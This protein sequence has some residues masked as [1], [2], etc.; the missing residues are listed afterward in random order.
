[1]TELEKMKK[2]KMYAEKLANG[3][4]PINDVPVPDEDI[5]NNVKISRCLFYISDILQQVID[6]GGV[7]KENKGPKKAF[8][9]SDEELSNFLISE[10]PI[11]ITEITKRLNAV[12]DLSTHY[13]LKLTDITSWLI[14]LEVL[15]AVSM[16]DGSSAKRPTQQGV[17]LGI[18]TETRTGKNG[19][20]TAVLYNKE[21]QQFIID[22]MDA[23]IMRLQEKK[24]NKNENQGQAWSRDHEECLLDLFQKGVSI[25]EIAVT[26]MRTEGAI[27]AR[28][29]KLGVLGADYDIE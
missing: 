4:D 3:I 17:D 6:N 16:S 26:L 1:M 20:Y 15:E 24:K 19:N 14:E 10:T 25:S 8:Y 27:L 22:N 7:V 12:A 23:V 28:L 11:S 9:V 5:I 13:K 29:K 21:A 18:F 2:A